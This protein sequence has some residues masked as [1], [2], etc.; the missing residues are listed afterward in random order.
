MKFE[1]GKFYKHAT[2]HYLY[3]CGIVESLMYGRCLVAEVNGKVFQGVGSDE[4]SAANFHEISKKEYL[5]A[6]GSPKPPADS[7]RDSRIDALTG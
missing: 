3:I 2:E 4:V 1:L 7:N 5:S 6:C